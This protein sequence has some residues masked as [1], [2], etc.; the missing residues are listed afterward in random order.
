MCAVLRREALGAPGKLLLNPKNDKAEI[1][2][3][4]RQR[5][6]MTPTNDRP[7]PDSDARLRRV[8]RVRRMMTV[9]TLVV[10]GVTEFARAGQ[11]SP[12][13]QICPFF[14][15]YLTPS[16]FDVLFHPGGTFRQ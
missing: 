15:D 16:L 4:G 1:I 7:T 12:G 9:A 14:G 10:L 6:R 11:F 8:A 5:N 3:A 2:Q 13:P